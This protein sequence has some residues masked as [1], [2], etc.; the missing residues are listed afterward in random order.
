MDKT[1]QEILNL[2][3][4]ISIETCEGCI[5]NYGVQ[6][7]H[8]CLGAFYYNLALK[9]AIERVRKEHNIQDN[10]EFVYEKHHLKE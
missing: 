4:R 8:S 1:I 7:G 6:H 5:N 9:K 3:F 10:L 2:A